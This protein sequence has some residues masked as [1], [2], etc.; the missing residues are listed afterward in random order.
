[1]HALIVVS[2]PLPDSLTH[3]VATAIAQGIAESDPQNSSELADLTQEGFNP[4]FTAE[5]MAAF[6]LTGAT[7][8]EVVAEQS[9]IDKADA[10]VLV[11]PVYWWSMPGLLKGW[12]DR[13]FS[14]G[15]AYE[16]TAD[17]NVVKKLGR[18]RVHLVALGAASQKNL[19]YSRVYR[20][21]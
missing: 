6:H 11:F 20:C 16:E 3:S 8:A 1:M 13:V 10:L 19:R 7:P 21:V 2:H 14:N 5:D 18:L 15:W 4:T 9:R 17:G 12:I